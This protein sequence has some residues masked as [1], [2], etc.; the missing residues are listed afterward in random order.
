MGTN[1][2][3]SAVDIQRTRVVA[4]VVNADQVWHFGGS[5]ESSRI[6]DTQFRPIANVLCTKGIN[7]L[8][9]KKVALVN[10]LSNLNFHFSNSAVV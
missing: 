10:Y 3:S 8:S 2:T 4:V 1:G 6:D 5:V 7:W 9:G